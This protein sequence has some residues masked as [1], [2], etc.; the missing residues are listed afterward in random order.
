MIYYQ[1][2]DQQQAQAQVLPH[3]LKVHIIII[4]MISILVHNTLPLLLVY[5]V[6]HILLPYME[7]V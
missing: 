4:A 1:S 7:L 2:P 3:L 5:I 6:L